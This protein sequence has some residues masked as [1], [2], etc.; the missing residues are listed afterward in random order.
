MRNAKSNDF[1]FCYTKA[2]SDYLSQQG[3][4]YILKAKSIKD[5]NVFTMYQKTD[6]LYSVLQEYRKQKS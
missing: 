5:N 2:V 3:I 6:E 1:F 4:Y